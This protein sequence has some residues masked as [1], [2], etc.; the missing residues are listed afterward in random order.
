[1]IK[2]IKGLLWL[3][4]KVAHSE[5]MF[6]NSMQYGAPGDFLSLH[7]EDN[8]H[9]SHLVNQRPVPVQVTKLG[10]GWALSPQCCLVTYIILPIGQEASIA[11]QAW[12]EV[13]CQRKPVVVTLLAK[14]W[15]EFWHLWVQMCDKKNNLWLN[16]GLVFAQNK[17]TD[18]RGHQ[19]KREGASFFQ[20][21][22]FNLFHR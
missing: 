8:I 7:L 10:P 18:K 6:Q 4:N 3:S 5:R 17:T 21:V 1:M 13:N 2:P 22:S 12:S 19:K 15:G 20:P 14:C 9:A 16:E 11:P